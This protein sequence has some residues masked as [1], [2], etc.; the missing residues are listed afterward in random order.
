MECRA[1]LLNQLRLAVGPGAVG[2]QHGGDGSIE[3][4]PQ[5]TAAESQMPN[6]VR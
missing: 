1:N 3:V 4:D 2:Q 6:G 5:R